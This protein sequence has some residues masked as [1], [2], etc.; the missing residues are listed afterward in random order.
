[1]SSLLLWLLGVI[2]VQYRV[3]FGLSVDIPVV[4]CIYGNT[5]AHTKNAWSVNVPRFHKHSYVFNLNILNI[6]SILPPPGQ[7][8]IL[9]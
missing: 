5:N 2:L 4:S 9:T 6:M 7:N 1:M 3:D 8:E